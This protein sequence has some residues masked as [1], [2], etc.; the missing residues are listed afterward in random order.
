MAIFSRRT[1]Q[2]LIFEN[3]SF[4]LRKDLKEQVHKLNDVPVQFIATEWEIILL[5]VLS[6]LG[7]VEHHKKFEGTSNIDIYYSDRKNTDE[8]FIADIA[9]ISDKG[10]NEKNPVEELDYWLSKITE[11]RGFDSNNFEL[12]ISGKRGY[13]FNGTITELKIPT[14]KEIKKGNENLLGEKFLKF[15]SEIQHSPNL[16]RRYLDDKF[17]IAIVY[18]P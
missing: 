16:A 2:R 8:S 10:R 13:K 14:F 5:N 7:N 17:A 9:T 4:T 15:L 11:D 12:H 3:A 6:K 18:S 1:I